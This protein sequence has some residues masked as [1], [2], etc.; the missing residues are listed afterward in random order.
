[1]F[2]FNKALFVAGLLVVAQVSANEE[3]PVIVEV[4][5]DV[6]DAV[7]PANDSM[8]ERT[9]LYRQAQIDMFEKLTDD[10]SVVNVSEINNASFFINEDYEDSGLDAMVRFP[11][12]SNVAIDFEDDAQAQMDLYNSLVPETGLKARLAAFVA[13]TTALAQ[14][15]ASAAKVWF[16]ALSKTKKTAVIA[17]GV[18]A[19]SLVAYGIYKLV[20][21]E[22]KAKKTAHVAKK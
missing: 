9:Q 22:K 3:A 4:A 21:K 20:K 5:Q 14:T 16:N 11:F 7:V 10:A 15:K 17:G 18:A 6:V 13:A 8:V 1:M 2:K 19:A 12:P